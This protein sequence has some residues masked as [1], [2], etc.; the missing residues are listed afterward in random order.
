ML[1]KLKAIL[2]AVLRRLA[3]SV[4]KEKHAFRWTY[5]AMQTSFRLLSLTPLT[6]DW[7]KKQLSGIRRNESPWAWWRWRLL[8]GI[9]TTISMAAVTLRLINWVLRKETRNEIVTA[10]DFSVVSLLS[11]TTT[12]SVFAFVYAE[13]IPCA[14]NTPMDFYERFHGTCEFLT[15]DY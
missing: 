12:M 4:T 14:W 9:A 11:L 5:F 8:L 10:F 1:S 13:S 3:P 2:L 6:W 15:C 7:K